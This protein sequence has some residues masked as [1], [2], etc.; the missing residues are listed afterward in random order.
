ILL[1]V[2][3]HP[4]TK[5]P[6]SASV[7]ICWLCVRENH[8]VERGALRCSFPFG[9]SSLPLHPSRSRPTVCSAVWC[10]RRWR[11]PISR[12]SLKRLHPERGA[13]LEYGH[14][15]PLCSMFP[16]ERNVPTV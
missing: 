5:K 2:S 3:T 6:K 16:C 10:S 7:F 9:I 13:P 1:L 14:S 8:P 4:E 15:P 12:S 11:S